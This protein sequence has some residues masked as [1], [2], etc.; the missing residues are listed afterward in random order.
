MQ[1]FTHIIKDPHGVHARPAGLIASAAKPFAASV[2]VSCG[3]KTADGKRLL[4][5]MSLG[6]RCGDA[7]CFRIEGD[8]ETEATETLRRRC[9]EVI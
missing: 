5:L 9:E 4:S 2:A 1:E 6:A 8:D 3:G 7:L